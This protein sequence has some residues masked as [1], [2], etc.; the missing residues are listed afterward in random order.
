M[1]ESFSKDQGLPAVITLLLAILLLVGGGGSF[2][3]YQRAQT[4][5]AMAAA[6][7]EQEMAQRALAERALM[8]TV[9][10][11]QTA[12]AA[13]ARADEEAAKAA[14]ISRFLVQVLSS[15]DPAA[16]QGRQLT[17]SDLLDRVGERIDAGELKTS[18]E[19]EASV[20]ST[21]GTTY[22]SLGL[23]GKAEAHLRAA[24]ELRTKALGASHPDVA[25]DQENLAKA[26][27]AQGK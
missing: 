27:Q 7:R 24:V 6:A 3:L 20:R 17:A 9:R 5:R 18:P 4:A 8:E 16:A 1:S 22:L 14:A 15:S 11:R 26:L 12:T 19:A 21:L 10:A 2:L 25:K 23:Y 13:G